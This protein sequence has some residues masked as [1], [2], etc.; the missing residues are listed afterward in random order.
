MQLLKVKKSTIRNVWKKYQL[1]GLG[2][3]L[4]C[5]RQTKK[6]TPTDNRRLCRV[7]IKSPKLAVSSIIHE[8]MPS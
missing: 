2:T 7:L 8:L 3:E 5:H 4:A 1:D 6:L